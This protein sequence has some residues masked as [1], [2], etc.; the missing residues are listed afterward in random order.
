MT[1]LGARFG[2][3]HHVAEEDNAI[4]SEVFLDGEQLLQRFLIGD[5][6]EELVLLQEIGQVMRDASICGLGQTASSAIE[7]ALATLD[8]FPEPATKS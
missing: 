5:R 3:V 4:R 6:A 1:F 2:C 8:P 7:S